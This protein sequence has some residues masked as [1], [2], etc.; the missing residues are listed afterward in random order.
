MCVEYRSASTSLSLRVDF[1]FQMSC[2]YIKINVISDHSVIIFL[3][4]KYKEIA[5]NLYI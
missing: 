3:V 1:I 4:I 2:Y 5:L